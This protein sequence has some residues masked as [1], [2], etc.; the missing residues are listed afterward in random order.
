MK[1][2]RHLLKQPPAIISIIAIIC[3]ALGSYTALTA[4]PTI[5]ASNIR[6]TS[7]APTSTDSYTIKGSVSPAASLTINNKQVPVESNGAFS[8]TITLDE[9][10]NIITM[11]TTKNG[12]STTRSYSLYRYTK[13]EITEQKTPSSKISNPAD[14]TPTESPAITQPSARSAPAPRTSFGDGRYTVG[15]DIAAGTYRTNNP[16]NC[17]YK[18]LSINSSSDGNSSSQGSGTRQITITISPNDETFSS[19][20]CGTWNRI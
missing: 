9:G 4:P 20:D 2:Y 8:Y 16:G 13:Q 1:N 18:I 10:N 17:H 6:E 12:K 7:N 5:E 15:T 19:D 3:I 14:T 11:T